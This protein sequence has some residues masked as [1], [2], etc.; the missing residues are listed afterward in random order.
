MPDMIFSDGFRSGTTPWSAVRG[1][2][3]LVNGMA[4]LQGAG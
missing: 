4:A 2:G 3:D 1:N